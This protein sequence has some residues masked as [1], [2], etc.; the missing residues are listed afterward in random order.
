MIKITVD[1]AV[2]EALQKAFAKPANTAHR[3]LA[4]YI[5]VLETM[6]FQSLHAWPGWAFVRPCPSTRPGRDW[7]Q[8]V[9]RRWLHRSAGAAGRR[10]RHFLEGTAGV[11][12]VSW[13]LK[14][15][16]ARTTY[17]GIWQVQDQVLQP[18]PA[19]AL[20]GTLFL[21]S[22]KPELVDARIFKNRCDFL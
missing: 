6:L 2:Y 14:E 4:K 12:V 15:A 3:A 18:L 1:S 21:V 9:A 7:R 22:A 11:R 13:R 5:S 19:I 16:G 17:R 8:P 10:S 20:D